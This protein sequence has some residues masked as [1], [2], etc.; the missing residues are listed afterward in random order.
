MTERQTLQ[1]PRDVRRAFRQ[2]DTVPLEAECFTLTCASQQRECP[3]GPEGIVSSLRQ[4]ERRLL[5]RQRLPLGGQR[6][7]GCDVL[8]RV[9]RNEAI[10]DGS[11]QCHG[12]AA[13]RARGRGGCL[14]FGNGL[15]DATDVLRGEAGDLLAA[16]AR[17]EV[18]SHAAL[19]VHVGLR[20][21]VRLCDVAQPLVEP[22]AHSDG[23]GRDAAGRGVLDAGLTQLGERALLRA[24]GPGPALALAIRPIAEV[25]RGDPEAVRALVERAV[26][27]EPTS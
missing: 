26:A 1:L 25:D 6:A 12:Q 3:A 18:Q 27:L 7:R 21:H 4:E 10:S 16:Q 13:V 14:V 15:L 19:V 9:A 17:L 2:V 22:V 11:R 20:A 24:T 5:G 8:G 23:L